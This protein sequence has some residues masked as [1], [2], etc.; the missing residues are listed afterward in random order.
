MKQRNLAPEPST[1]N[2]ETAQRLVFNPGIY[3]D[4]LVNR[5]E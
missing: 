5:I 3:F 1:T 2:S 4:I